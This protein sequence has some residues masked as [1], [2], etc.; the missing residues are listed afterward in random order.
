[1]TLYHPLHCCTQRPPRLTSVSDARNFELLW[2]F[3]KKVPEIPSHDL[4]FC[5]ELYKEEKKNV[6]IKLNQHLIVNKYKKPEG[7]FTLKL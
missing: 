6:D 2:G 5:S 4:T 3:A 7:L 1:M